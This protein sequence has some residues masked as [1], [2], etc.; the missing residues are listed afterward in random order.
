MFG[1]MGNLILHNFEIINFGSLW[2][3]FYVGK[4]KGII[5]YGGTI[6]VSLTQCYFMILVLVYHKNLSQFPLNHQNKKLN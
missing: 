1:I 5:S 6:G 4:F 3:W 2:I